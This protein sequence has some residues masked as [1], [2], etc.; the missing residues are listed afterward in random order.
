MR[1]LNR[2]VRIQQGDLLAV[3]CSYDSTRVNGSVVGGFSSQQEMC[4]VFFFYYNRVNN[5][6]QCSSEIE[7]PEA[8]RRF[9]GIGNVTWSNREVEFIVNEPEN[10]AGLRVSQVSDNLVDWS[11]ERREELQR[12]HLETPHKNRCPRELYS[13]PA[14]VGYRQLSSGRSE[15]E[16]D[17]GWRTVGYPY[18]AAPYQPPRSCS[19]Q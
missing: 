18:Q 12:F 10:L 4:A 2:E 16:E 15:N 6:V 8:R 14:S 13:L 3:R 19:F 1:A 11:V 17:E 7:S 9:L 5:Y